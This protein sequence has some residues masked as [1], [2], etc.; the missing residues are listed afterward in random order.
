[1]IGYSFA[2]GRLTI[3]CIDKV[4]SIVNVGSTWIHHTCQI[5]VVWEWVSSRYGIGRDIRAIRLSRLLIL[6]PIVFL[7]FNQIVNSGLVTGERIV[8]ELQVS[9]VRLS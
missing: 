3:N 2:F 9:I 7:M 4:C 1:M 5:E 6:G 8:K